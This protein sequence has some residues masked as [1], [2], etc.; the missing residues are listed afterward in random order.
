MRFIN[1]LKEEYVLLASGFYGHS[2]PIFVNPSPKE[3]RQAV[4]SDGWVRYLLVTK[5]KKLYIWNS[6]MTH[7]DA[8]PNL[9]HEN[10]I[11]GDAYYPGKRGYIWGFAQIKGRSLVDYPETDYT[12]NF[13]KYHGIDKLKDDWTFKYFNTS[14][15]KE[16]RTAVGITLKEEYTTTLRSQDEP[17]SVYKNPSADDF[18][19][20][21]KEIR[22]GG[23]SK[24]S[25]R[26]LVDMEHQVIYVWD[27]NRALH[28]TVMH[29]LA[30][31]TNISNKSIQ[32]LSVIK[33]NKISLNMVDAPW[34]V[35]F[36]W[37][38]GYFI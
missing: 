30:K 37:C 3:M 7:V 10:L 9:E 18:K 25:V 23:D 17:Y 16:M 14:L 35:D 1:Y 29:E 2:Y 4:D 5:E 12:I 11:P 13:I 24:L 27:A 33:N 38:K 21:A 15:Y 6:S 20:L 36:P 19:E 28:Y 34:S 8:A 32:I 26:A 31:T 22:K